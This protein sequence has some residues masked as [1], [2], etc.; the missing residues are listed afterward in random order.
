M[1]A[2]AIIV[3]VIIYNVRRG[4]GRPGAGLPLGRPGGQEPEYTYTLNPKP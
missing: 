3:A 2:A 4:R 1:I